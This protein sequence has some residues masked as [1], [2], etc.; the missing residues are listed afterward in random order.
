MSGIEELRRRYPW[1]DERPD[2]PEDWAGWFGGGNQRILGELL[3]TETKIVVELGSL[4]GL[5]AR[6]LCERAPFAVVICIDHWKGSPEHFVRAEQGRPGWKE[7]LPR[8]YETFCGNMWPWRDRVVP[9]KTTTLEGLREL[10]GLQ[11]SPDLI[12]VDAAHDSESVTNDVAT[13]MKLFPQAALVGD[14]WGRGDVR[15]GVI[16]ATHRCRFL[17]VEGWDAWYL[18]AKGRAS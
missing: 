9:M 10:H 15:Q 14:D 3:S 7:R 5:S 8:L 6:F 1:P 2:A 4:C 16:E 18:P 12:Y 17:G 11:I 13:S